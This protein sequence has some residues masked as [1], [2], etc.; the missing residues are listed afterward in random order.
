MNY[1]QS[2]LVQL[3]S[4]MGKNSPPPLTLDCCLFLDVDGT[5]I[6]F[7][8]SPEESVVDEKLKFLL[9]TILNKL[10]GALALVSGRS[11][12][13]LDRLFA[14]L[15]F[16][17]AGLHGIERRDLNGSLRGA[18]FGDSR[19][20]SLKVA[21]QE[22]TSAHPNTHF[23]DKGRAIAMHFRNDPEQEPTIRKIFVDAVARL[24]SQY[25][26]QEGHFVLEIKPS[27]FSKGTAIK[28][29]LKEQPFS[30]RLPI[31][32]GDDL[33]DRDGFRAVEDC[34]GMSIAVGDRVQAQWRL[35]DPAA[36]R[37]WLSSLRENSSAS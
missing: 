17:A 34:D 36:V 1:W 25:H 21:L 27:G 26:I 33:T 23:E 4:R 3:W 16:A 8:D 35:E 9:T 19:L 20:N 29:F 5:L 30:G 18:G 10:D 15:R 24:G 6:E 14:P 12:V 13:S 22:I 28:A 2:E 7:S 37:T 11:I 32:I 31:F